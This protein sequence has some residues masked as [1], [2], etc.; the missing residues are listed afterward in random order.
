MIG[1]CKSCEQEKEL[2]RFQKM[3]GGKF[4]FRKFCIPCWSAERNGYQ[5]AWR[6]KNSDR[7]KIYDR[8][9]Y[10]KNPE[11][12]AETRR[13]HYQKWKKVVFDHYGHE[14]ACCGES[15]PKFLTIDHADDNGAEHR[16]EVA[17]GSTLF[18]W[19]VDNGF[20]KSFRILCF[21]CNSGRYHNGGVCPHEAS[22]LNYTKPSERATLSLEQ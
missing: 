17:P 18:R 21:N 1:I 14:C 10:R 9:K 15:E 11:Y 20:P 22:R 19:L 6:E 13:R 16:K 5:S 8:I 4:Y 12:Q 7:L 3:K 2:A